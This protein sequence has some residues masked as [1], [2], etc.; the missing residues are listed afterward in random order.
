MDNLWYQKYSLETS[1][2][3]GKTDALIEVAKKMKAKGMDVKEIMEMTG[4]DK[5]EVEKL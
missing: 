5:E 1:Y 3:D 4:L 2:D